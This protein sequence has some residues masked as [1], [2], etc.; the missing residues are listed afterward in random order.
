MDAGGGERLRLGSREA[1][2]SGDRR[3]ETKSVAGGAVRPR[4]SLLPIHR[5]ETLGFISRARHAGDGAALGGVP[6]GVKGAAQQ[7][8][9]MGDLVVANAFDL[10]HRS[11]G[12]ESG[13]I[14]ERTW[15]KTTIS[16]RG[17]QDPSIDR[18][19]PPALPAVGS[20]AQGGPDRR[21]MLAKPR[22]AGR[23][24]AQRPRA[25]FDAGIAVAELGLDGGET[26][27]G[28]GRG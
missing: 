22:P 12:E 3:S 21:V 15:R 11:Q 5:G 19:E 10:D 16:P 25:E 18:E 28:F 9:P 2:R 8:K 13:S 26:G 27:H 17:V 1:E 23:G 24:V 6:G 20:L 4:A 7:I 14:Q